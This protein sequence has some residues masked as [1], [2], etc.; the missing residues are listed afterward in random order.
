[1]PKIIEES[2]GGFLFNTEKELLNAMDQL[3]G[4]QNLRREVGRRGATLAGLFRQFAGL[5]AFGIGKHADRST[6][7]VRP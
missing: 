5:L 7:K 3:L 2:G 4:D 1:M 6:K